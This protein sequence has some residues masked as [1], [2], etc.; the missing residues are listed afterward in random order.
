MKIRKFTR[1]AAVSLVLLA[2]AVFAPLPATA[3][4]VTFHFTGRLTVPP[5]ELA[6]L[7]WL[8]R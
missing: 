8:P 4:I 1:H 3:D 5:L 6:I 2:A 7:R